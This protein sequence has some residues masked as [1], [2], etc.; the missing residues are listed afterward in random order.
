MIDVNYPQITIEKQK[1]PV[2]LSEHEK[3]DLRKLVNAAMN[4]KLPRI[5]FNKLIQLKARLSK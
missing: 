4:D 5:S 3:K 2:C 1:F